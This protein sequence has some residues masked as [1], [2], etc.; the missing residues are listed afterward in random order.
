MVQSDL[1]G[2]GLAGWCAQFPP[3]VPLALTAAL[4]R[5]SRPRA[6]AVRRQC[7]IQTRPEKQEGDDAPLARV[8]LPAPSP[9]SC[10]TPA[11]AAEHLRRLRSAVIQA[12]APV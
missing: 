7:S 6:N 2:C 10:V 5:R 3:G 9:G 11:G 12:R 4:A 8:N 1:R